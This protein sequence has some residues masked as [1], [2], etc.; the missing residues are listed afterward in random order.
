[1]RFRCR[2]RGKGIPFASGEIYWSARQKAWDVTI[3]YDR[4]SRFGG[5]FAAEEDAAHAYDVE[6]RRVRRARVHGGSNGNGVV[7]RLNFPYTKEVTAVTSMLM[8]QR[9][10]EGKKT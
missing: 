7:F 8:K 9:L 10:H 3:L 5:Y 4:K 6:A 1:V 2:T